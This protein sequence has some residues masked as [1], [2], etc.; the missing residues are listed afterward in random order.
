MAA[1]RTHENVADIIDSSEDETD[2]KSS[3][4]VSNRKFS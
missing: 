3:T 2:N 1:K 4:N